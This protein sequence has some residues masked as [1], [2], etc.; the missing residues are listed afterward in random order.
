MAESNPNN[1]SQDRDISIDGLDD[2]ESGAF[3]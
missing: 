3:D 2:I 1:E